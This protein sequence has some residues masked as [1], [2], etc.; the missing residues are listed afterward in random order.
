MEKS[1]VGDDVRANVIEVPICSLRED[2]EPVEGCVCFVCETI[3]EKD[4]KNGSA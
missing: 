2:R 3:R 4:K 1:P